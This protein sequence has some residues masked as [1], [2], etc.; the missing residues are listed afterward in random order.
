MTLEKYNK[1]MKFLSRAKYLT[2][3]F[4]VP[5]FTGTEPEIDKKTLEE[6]LKKQKLKKQR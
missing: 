3:E 5:L 1:A 6:H 2:K 4:K